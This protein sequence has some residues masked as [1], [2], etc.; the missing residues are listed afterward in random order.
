MGAWEG[1]KFDISDWALQRKMQLI[2]FFLMFFTL[3]QV[4]L[5]LNFSFFYIL[6]FKEFLI[7]FRHFLFKDN[8]LGLEE[9]RPGTLKGFTENK[10][11]L[12]KELSLVL[13]LIRQ[14]G[15]QPLL[16]GCSVV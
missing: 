15:R 7:Y 8:G 3:L 6:S 10:E 1:I 13:E 9:A 2:T 11:F 5:T 16:F 14:L 12:P 4:F